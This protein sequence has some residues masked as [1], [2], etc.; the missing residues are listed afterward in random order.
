M[1]LGIGTAPFQGRAICLSRSAVFPKSSFCSASSMLMLL[2]VDAVLESLHPETGS[3]CMPCVHDATMQ[4]LSLGTEHRHVYT[5][6]VCINL[7]VI[8]LLYMACPDG[9]RHKITFLPRLRPYP[10]RG[11]RL[12]CCLYTQLLCL[13]FILRYKPHVSVHYDMNNVYLHSTIILRHKSHFSV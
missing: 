12:L 10:V 4:V 11:H 2:T 5:M 7:V 9:C 3:C 1:P 13:T 8:G 6:H